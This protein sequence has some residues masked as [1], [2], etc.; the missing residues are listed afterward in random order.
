MSEKLSKLKIFIV[1]V[2][3]TL[4][5]AYAAYYFLPPHN[6]LMYIFAFG[7]P[8]ILHDIIRYL[9]KK[10]KLPRWFYKK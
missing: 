2:V 4:S 10:N 3:I 7:L 9:D 8:Y 6:L 5:L 1:N